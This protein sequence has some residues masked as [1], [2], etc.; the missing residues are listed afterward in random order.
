MTFEMGS[1]IMMHIIIKKEESYSFH[2]WARLS[3]DPFL[4]EEKVYELMWRNENRNIHYYYN[5]K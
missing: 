4:Q 2:D 1:E 5:T 3:W